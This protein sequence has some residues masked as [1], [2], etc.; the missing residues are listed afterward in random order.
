MIRLAQMARP[1]LLCLNDMASDHP[2]PEVDAQLTAYMT[3]LFPKPSPF[4]KPP[5]RA[6]SA[7]LRRLQSAA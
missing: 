3:G 4:E 1:Y 2:T 6:C 5:D 7:R